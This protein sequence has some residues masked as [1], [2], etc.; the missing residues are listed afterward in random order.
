[1]K[2]A[3]E[4]LGIDTEKTELTTASFVHNTLTYYPPSIYSA[5]KIGLLNVEIVSFQS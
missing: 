3:A 5:E 1:M 4:A 2:R